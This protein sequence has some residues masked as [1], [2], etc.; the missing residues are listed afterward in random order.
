MSTNAGSSDAPTTREHEKLYNLIRRIAMSSRRDDDD[1]SSIGA[2]HSV[3]FRTL[4]DREVP[5]SRKDVMGL[6]ESI[7]TV[8]RDNLEMTGSHTVGTKSQTATLEWSCHPD[9][10]LE[11]Q[12]VEACVFSLYVD[13][14]SEKIMM[15]YNEEAWD[16]KRIRYYPGENIPELETYASKGPT[17]IT[18]TVRSASYADGDAPPENISKYRSGIRIGAR[19]GLDTTSGEALDPVGSEDSQVHTFMERF[20]YPHE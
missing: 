10:P 17:Q 11:G 7:P 16:L 6:L 2:L 12:D 9:R 8:M 13:P 14:K 19:R 20:E 4:P 5:V 18:V 3:P 15:G 1:T